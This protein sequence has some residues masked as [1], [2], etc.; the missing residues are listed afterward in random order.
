MDRVGECMLYGLRVPILPDECVVVRCSGPYAVRPVCRG[1]IANS[2]EW[3]VLNRHQLRG[4][5]RL[6]L[7]GGHDE[8]D[9]LADIAYSVTG[10]RPRQ[11]GLRAITAFYR[12][13]ARKLTKAI[14]VKMC[15]CE[16]SQDTWGSQCRSRIDAQNV[17]MG[18]RRPH[19]VSTGLVL[20]VQVV[21]ELTA[22]AQQAVVLGTWCRLANKRRHR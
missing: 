21:E 4:I 22:P 6:H 17:R 11:W 14:A 8:S 3:T 5:A 16:D 20:E 15:G 18:V 9:R 19:D 12:Q 10:K 1:N 2:G 7:A 13:Q